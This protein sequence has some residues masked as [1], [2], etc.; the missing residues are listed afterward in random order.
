MAKVEEDATVQ[1]I[2][3]DDRF[4]LPPDAAALIFK[5]AGPD[6]QM[7]IRLV[8]PVGVHPQAVS[9]SPS[10]AAQTAMQLLMEQLKSDADPDPKCG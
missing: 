2:S 4:G 8:F 3:G 5:P 10:L 9:D 7:D 1:V 6:G